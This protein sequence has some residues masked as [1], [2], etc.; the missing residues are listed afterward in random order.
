MPQATAEHV[1]GLAERIRE[2]L[3][4]AL[5]SGTTPQFTA[6][7]GVSDYRQA[8]EFDAV[9]A[10]ADAALLA[11]KRAGRNRVVVAADRQP[12]RVAPGPG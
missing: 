2:A 11:A 7:F 10:L 9:V 1:A 4:L 3:T 12:G 6:S 5:A 8:D